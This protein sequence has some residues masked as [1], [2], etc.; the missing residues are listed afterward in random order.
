[1][2]EPE[3]YYLNLSP[4]DIEDRILHMVPYNKNISLSNEEKALFRN[5]IDA[6]KASSGFIILGYFTTVEDLQES[7]SSVPEPGD[8]YGIGTGTVDDPYHIYIYDGYHNLWVDNGPLSTATDLI[9]DGSIDSVAV[10]WSAYKL[11]TELSGKQS[12]I[13]DQGMLKGLSNGIVESAVLGEDYGA[14]S[15]TVTLRA[16]SWTDNSQDVLN[17]NFLASGY[18]YIIAPTSTDLAAYGDAGI[19]ADDIT[20]DT[21]MKFHCETEPTANITVNVIRVISA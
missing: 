18:S 1:M 11:Y 13:T 17:I 8:A 4:E 5:N 21:V 14:K 20:E 12:K 15:F 6:G 2:S 3:F 10:S 9:D 16:A 7:L 19:Y